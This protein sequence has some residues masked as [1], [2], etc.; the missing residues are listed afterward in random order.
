MDVRKSFQL[1]TCECIHRILILNATER[2]LDGIPDGTRC[3]QRR[4][5]SPE[6]R[7]PQA[8]NVAKQNSDRSAKAGIG[9]GSDPRK[10]TDWRN[11]QEPG[12]RRNSITLKTLPR[13]SSALTRRSGGEPSVHRHFAY[14]H[15]RRGDPAVVEIIG[16]A[17]WIGVPSVVLGEL[18]TGFSRGADAA[19]NEDEL[20]K[21]SAPF[22]C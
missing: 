14:G 3:A 1:T 15:F 17:R 2:T 21:F 20:R 13:S 18:R 5:Q 22:F 6:V 12:V 19:R 10:R 8:W 16:M 4:C 7:N 9:H 11:L